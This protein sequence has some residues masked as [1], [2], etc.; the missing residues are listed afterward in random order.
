MDEEE[1]A[2][3]PEGDDVKSPEDSK[4]PENQPNKP[5]TVPYDAYKKKMDDNVRLNKRVKELETAET[6]RNTTNQS[7]TQK[8]QKQLDD[9]MALLNTTS[10][11]LRVAKVEKQVGSTARSMNFRDP[12]D[13]F[14]LVRGKL[15]VDDDGTVLNADDLLADLA[16]NKP[17]LLTEK[18]APPATTAKPAAKQ[19]VQSGSP[20][21]PAGG[22]KTQI[23]TRAE[24]QAMKPQDI[25]KGLQSGLFDDILKGN[26]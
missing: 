12:E 11:E 2:L 16:K 18:A 4:P 1:D 5:K 13:A 7:E 22:T 25:V 9:A 14:Q 26:K 20:A 10:A 6:S 21:N 8:L 17:Y 3:P 19:P 15:E 23:K 24:I